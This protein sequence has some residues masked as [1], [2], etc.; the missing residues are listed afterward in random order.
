MSTL[1]IV[2]AAQHVLCRRYLEL[3]HTALALKASRTGWVRP[4]SHTTR[5]GELQLA[6]FAAVLSLHMH[7]SQCGVPLTSS[8]L[9]RSNVGSSVA[10]GPLLTLYANTLPI[11]VRL[12]ASTSTSVRGEDGCALHPMLARQR[13]GTAGKSSNAC[14]GNT[15]RQPPVQLSFTTPRARAVT[16]SKTRRNDAH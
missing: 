3:L 5:L 2:A 7:M 6:R 12:K 8:L 11:K 13:P 15:Y 10:F 14:T 1:G 4:A 9:Q 16:E